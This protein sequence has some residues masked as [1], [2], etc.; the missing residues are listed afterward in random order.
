MSIQLIADATLHRRNF[1]NDHTLKL[2]LDLECLKL[3]GVVT[4]ERK[5]FLMKL[6]R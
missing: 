5:P 1:L 4:D 6:H 2:F 3:D